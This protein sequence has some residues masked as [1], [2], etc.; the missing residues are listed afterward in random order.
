MDLKHGT[1]NMNQICANLD[2]HLAG[3]EQ[4][5]SNFN[6]RTDT[7]KYRS[8][9]K[10]CCT[11]RSNN[12]YKNNKDKLLVK[13]KE[14]VIKNKEKI[15]IQRKE[16]SDANKLAKKEYDKLYYQQNRDR[17]IKSTS[18]YK[19]IK[20]K[21]DLCIRLQGNISHLIRQSLKAKNSSKNK[22]SILKYLPYSIQEL[23]IHIELQFEVWMSWDNYGKY[24][25]DKWNDNDQLTW[26]WQIDHIIPHSTFKYTNMED[27][28]FLECWSLD[29]LRPLSSKQNLL[30]GN[31]RI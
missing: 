7:K 26:T 16:Y 5:L 13:A 2:C 23:K 27:E 15:R 9:C 12:F 4:D 30:D 29:N 22:K 3:V 21:E 6:F 28:K 25:I 20:R 14:Y 8:E 31:R 1:Q 19:K 10:I 11:K 24:Y 17:L 18:E